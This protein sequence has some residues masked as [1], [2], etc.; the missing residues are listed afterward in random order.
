MHTRLLGQGARRPLENQNQQNA[1]GMGNNRLPAHE[2]DK[3]GFTPDAPV[4]R[5][6]NKPARCS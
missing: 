3:A 4:I 2:A 1:A 5:P 6:S